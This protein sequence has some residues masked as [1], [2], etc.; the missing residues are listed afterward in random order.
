MDSRSVNQSAEHGGTVVFMLALLHNTMY[1][2]RDQ[3]H[4]LRE[5][6]GA[7]YKNEDYDTVPQITRQVTGRFGYLLSDSMWDLYL[8]GIYSMWE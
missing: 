7:G 6:A 1:L 8:K 3:G 2:C 5:D 4:P